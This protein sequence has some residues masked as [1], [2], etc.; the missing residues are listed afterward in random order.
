METTMKA[1]SRAEQAESGLCA[2][3]RTVIA[4][5]LLATLAAL[6]LTSF[7][8]G[9]KPSGAEE[10]VLAASVPS[11]RTMPSFVPTDSGETSRFAFGHLEFDWDPAN[12]VPG[13]DSWPTGSSR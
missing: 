3:E 5:A 1:I 9:S 8:H 6:A 13:F 7:I 4:P 2:L 11:M 10:R 12:G